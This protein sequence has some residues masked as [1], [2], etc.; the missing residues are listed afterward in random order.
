LITDSGQMLEDHLLIFIFDAPALECL[1]DFESQQILAPS[2]L[3][4]KAGQFFQANW[5]KTK[6][7]GHIVSFNQDFNELLSNEYLLEITLN[8]Y[9]SAICFKPSA[10]EVSEIETH[11]KRM[12]EGNPPSVNLL[13]QR[14]MLDVLLLKMTQR[15]Y[16]L[17]QLLKADHINTFLKLE[18]LIEKHICSEKSVAFYADQLEYTPK[19]LNNICHQFVNMSAKALLINRL[20][21]KINRMLSISSNTIASV[22]K[23]T[24][25]AEPTNFVKFYKQHTGTLPS[26][27][28]SFI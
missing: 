10:G 23:K 19:T 15:K 13:I 22:S 1:I 28:R 21:V 4:V 7:K 9:L 8:N 27:F 26:E 11:L 20:L 6:L 3:T 5:S 25:F 16:K 17:Y 2:V 24:G 14:H 12:I 18:R